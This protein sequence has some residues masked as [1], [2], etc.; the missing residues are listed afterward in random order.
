LRHAGKTQLFTI[1]KVLKAMV[2]KAH[3]LMQ[4]QGSAS[5]A[6]NKI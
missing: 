1:A 3:T 6:A 5:A 2:T 4:N